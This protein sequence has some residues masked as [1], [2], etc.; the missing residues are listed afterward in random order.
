MD[1]YRIAPN[2]ARS[3]GEGDVRDSPSPGRGGVGGEVWLVRPLLAIPRAAIEA[4]CTAHGLEPRFDRSNE[5]TTFF[6]NRLR[7]ELLPILE[8]Y[9]P[10]FARCWR[11][12]PKCWQ[13]ITRF[14]GRTW[15]RRGR[16]SIGAGLRYRSGGAGIT[17]TRP[18]VEFDLPAWR[19]LPIGLQRATIREAIHRLLRNLRNI[20]WEHV[21][22][23]LAAR[24]GA[25]GQAATLA[26]GLELQLGYASLRIATE[27]TAWTVDAP[28]V[29]G[30]MP[31]NAPGVTPIGD[32]WQVS[33]RRL[34]CEELPS[35]YAANADPWIAYLDAGITGAELILRP[36]QPG[37]RFQPQGLDGHSM[38]LNEFM[39][40][41]KAP[42]DAAP[43]GR[44]WSGSRA[45]PGSAACASMSGRRWG[46]RRVRYGRCGLVDR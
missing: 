13:G 6:R 36:R 22:R 26:A 4:Y 41:A 15:R 5:D 8:G 42:G 12:Q 34:R 32:G 24:E 28:Q 11:I 37:D 3:R 35:D 46:G 29:A 27:G 44:C 10:A 2:P 25:T 1:A 20:N 19:A 14:C 23:G 21:E 9:N 38:K 16:G 7:H 17:Q 43:A 31:L 30:P 40:N 39:I 33:V 45:S 18:C